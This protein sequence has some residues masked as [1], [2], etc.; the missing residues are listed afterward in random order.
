[1]LVLSGGIAK[2]QIF[3]AAVQ[4]EVLLYDATLFVGSLVIGGIDG[5][6]VYYVNILDS[7]IGNKEKSKGCLQA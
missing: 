3:I 2:A 1:M 4:Y 7:G 6:Y 5:L